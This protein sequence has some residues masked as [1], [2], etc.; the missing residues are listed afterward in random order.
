MCAIFEM[1][2]KWVCTRATSLVEDTGVEFLFQVKGRSDGACFK[3]K[4]Q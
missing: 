1:V 3:V 4:V 2:P